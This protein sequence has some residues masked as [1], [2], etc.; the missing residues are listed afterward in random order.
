MVLNTVLPTFAIIGVGALYGLLTGA[1]TSQISD[2]ILYVA[3][4]CLIIT[5]LIGRSFETREMILL[6]GTDLLYIFLPGLLGLI[7][8]DRKRDRGL[9]LPVMFQNTG[10][11]GLPLALFAWGEAGMQKAVVLYATSAVLMY[12]IGAWI[13][14]GFSKWREIF[15]LPLVYAVV[16][17]IAM[18]TLGVGM[19]EPLDRAVS[20]IGNTTIPLLA[21]VLGIF[22][23][24]A[25]A[26][27]LG[28]TVKGVVLRI[29]VGLLIG[30]VV[31]WLL[32]VE[33]LTRKVILLYSIMPSAIMTT[34]FADRYNRNPELVAAVVFVSTIV[35][36]ILIPFMLS[37]LG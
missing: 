8:L 21:F 16:I 24:K 23:S 2:Y 13:P 29:G 10:S 37:F 18:N 35:S 3:A 25:K 1:R 4:P 19:P 17:S 20:M 26:V 33:G 34:V 5:S 22:L 9:F 14:V 7:L 27:S 11:L 15:K 31:V 28:K 36:L 32:H 6:V 12:T 30:F